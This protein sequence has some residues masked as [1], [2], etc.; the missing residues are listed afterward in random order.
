[1]KKS[2]LNQQEVENLNRLFAGVNQSK[3]ANENKFPG[4]K[5][6]LNQHLKGVRP[7][8][9]EAAI[10]YAKGLKCKISDISPRISDLLIEASDYF[11]HSS[12][13][14]KNGNHD[15]PFLDVSK[16]EWSRISDRTK[17]A[18]ENQVKMMIDQDQRRSQES[19]QEIAA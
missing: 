10:C 15:W 7:I 8:S 2:N 12:T 6:M 19:I 4:G 3:F 17:G 9:I 14:H 18:I 16:A 11:D 13:D 5:S 1:M